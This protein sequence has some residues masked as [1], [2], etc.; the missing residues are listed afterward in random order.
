MKP[1]V[2]KAVKTSKRNKS[3]QRIGLIAIRN[4]KPIKLILITQKKNKC[5]H[6]GTKKEWTNWSSY[7]DKSINRNKFSEKHK[8]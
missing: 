8:F 3:L 6:F 1:G 7:V 2:V 4:L 5:K